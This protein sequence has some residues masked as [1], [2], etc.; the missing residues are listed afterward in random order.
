M[1]IVLYRCR[2]FVLGMPKPERREKSV[3]SRDLGAYLGRPDT[4]GV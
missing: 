4:Y 3:S 1:L 2:G